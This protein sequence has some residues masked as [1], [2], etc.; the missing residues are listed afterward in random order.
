[1]RSASA[2][3]P[4]FGPS[5]ASRASS[6]SRTLSTSVAAFP[7]RR[8]R[9]RAIGTRFP[10]PCGTTRPSDFSRPIT[11]SSFRSWQLPAHAGGR[12]ISLGK[13][14]QLPADA[15]SCTRA[16][17]LHQ[18]GFALGGKLTR[19]RAPHQSFTCVRFG[20]S[21]STSTR[22]P[23]RGYPCLRIQV[24]GAPPGGT[25]TPGCSAMPGAT[26]TPSSA[27]SASGRK[28][29]DP[30]EARLEA[31]RACGR[32]PPQIHARRAWRPAPLCC[33]E[34]KPGPASG[35][36][37]GCAWMGGKGWS[38]CELF[39]TSGCDARSTVMA[40]G[41]GLSDEAGRT[42]ARRA[43]AGRTAACSAGEGGPRR[44]GARGWWRLMLAPRAREGVRRSSCVAPA[45]APSRMRGHACPWDG[46]GGRRG[47]APWTGS[48]LRRTMCAAPW[49]PWGKMA[50]VWGRTLGVVQWGASHLLR[51]GG[52]SPSTGP[53]RGGPHALFPL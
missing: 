48:T 41:G 38:R 27:R 21:P 6:G 31:L 7:P 40:V 50:R 14:L 29:G 33:A 9:E 23:S 37:H 17:I 4:D 5:A 45:R 12:E 19:P 43:G 20:R 22:L 52:R 8:P 36:A 15:V 35:G 28:A 46:S 30:D 2:V 51:C 18:L 26:P 47:P 42:M 39:E 53:G 11:A 44:A 1:V 32:L 10:G 13:T 25:C 3:A 16:L 34:H 24:V 49:D